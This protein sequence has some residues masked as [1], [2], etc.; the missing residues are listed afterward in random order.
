MQH[1]R[2]SFAEALKRL[3]SASGLSQWDLVISIQ[4]RG[5]FPGVGRAAVSHWESGRRI[6]P[7]HH[8]L[9]LLDALEPSEEEAVKLIALAAEA[10]AAYGAWMAGRSSAAGGADTPAAL[11]SAFR[12]WGAASPGTARGED[13]PDR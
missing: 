11:L 9:C 4:D 12:V 7:P 13:M 6:P 3:R 5:E 1:P 8:L 2:A 10:D